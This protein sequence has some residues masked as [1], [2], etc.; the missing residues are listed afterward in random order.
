[1][2]RGPLVVWLLVI[3]IVMT[4]SIFATGIAKGNGETV[5][6]SLS[7][8]AFWVVFCIALAFFLISGPPK[9]TS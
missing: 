3:L 9:I 1:M 5:R 7:L 6:L 8:G 2:P 4:I